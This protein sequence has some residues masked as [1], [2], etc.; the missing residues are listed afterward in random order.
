MKCLKHFLNP[1]EF[2]TYLSKLHFSSKWR[3][4]EGTMN[5]RGAAIRNRRY[6]KKLKKYFS[7]ANIFRKELSIAEMFDSYIHLL[8]VLEFLEL[9][10]DETIYN[11]IEI[12]L[13]YV[14]DYSKGSRVDCMMIYNDNI[15]I[16]EFTCVNKYEKMKTAFD[17]KKL[18]LLIYKDMMYNYMV[19]KRIFSFA[20][21][22]IYE[23]HHGVEI[24]KHIDSNHKQ[25]EFAANFIERF[26][27]TN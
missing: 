17:K 16:F 14:V 19:D 20:F 11:N 12:V 22:S 21:V 8:R 9:K 15:C 6:S 1:S 4:E 18:E 26:L 23:Y 5:N 13:E 24:Q 10:V 27:L 25:A 7:D 3:I 2:I